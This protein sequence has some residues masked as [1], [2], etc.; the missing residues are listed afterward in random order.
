MTDEAAPA[1][2]WAAIREA[3]EDRKLKV[4]EIAAQF[5][6]APATIYRRIDDED[7]ER[8]HAGGLRAKRRAMVRRLGKL[9]S[10]ELTAL[11]ESAQATG[12]DA[13]L[14]DRERLAKVAAGLV[15]L[16][17]SITALEAELERTKQAT[18]TSNDR[19]GVDD[20]TLRRRI[21]QRIIA[22]CS[23]APAEADTGPPGGE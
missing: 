13:S 11:E 17:E 3:Y 22:L 2:D 9:V 18:R 5:G 23:E 4:T 6:V 14:A 20:D 15:K 8:R 21:A 19:S 1:P 12:Q 16:M 10:R 7:W